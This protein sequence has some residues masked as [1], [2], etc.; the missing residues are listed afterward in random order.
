MP[1]T[2][3]AALVV[4]VSLVCRLHLEARRRLRMTLR[5]TGKPREPMN[6]PRM[7][8]RHSIQS[9]TYGARPCSVGMNPALLKAEMP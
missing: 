3:S 7:I 4:R 1:T 8:G 9:P 2:T 6:T 5:M